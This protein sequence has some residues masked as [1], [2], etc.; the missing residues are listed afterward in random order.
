M[1]AIPNLGKGPSALKVGVVSATYTRPDGS[2]ARKLERAIKSLLKQTYENWKL[3]LV[4]DSYTDTE[5]LQR[6]IDWVPEDKIKTIL[7]D[8]PNIPDR[9]SLE[10]VLN[11]GVEAYSTGVMAL[12]SEGLDLGCQLCDDDFWYPGH[13][14]TLLS[15]YLQYPEAAVLYTQAL[16]RNHP[17]PDVDARIEYDNLPPG[18]TLE[19]DYKRL[20]Q[21]LSSMMFR[22]SCFKDRVR[23]RGIVDQGRHWPSDMDFI[24]QVMNVCSTDNLK[25]VYIPQVT[26]HHDIETSDLLS[27]SN[28]WKG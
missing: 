1:V 23:P 19:G 7:L 15:Y 16:Y 12:I 28:T 13:L 22:T 18:F 26:V 2:S 14:Q 10:A 27:G 3:F 9:D 11:G 21:I 8:R 25:T 20:N 4:S 5:H 17:Y 24:S 6:V